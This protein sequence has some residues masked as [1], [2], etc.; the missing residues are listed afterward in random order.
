MRGWT[1]SSA[2]LILLASLATACA[3]PTSTPV[4]QG[5]Q[6]QPS[7]TPK[8]LT[9]VIHGNPAVFS[10]ILSPPGAAGSPPGLQ[11]MEELMNAGL[12]NADNQ[13]R[14]RPQL[15]EAV[16]SLENGLW[17]VQGD[18]RMETTWKIR[19]T[20]AWHDGTTFTSDDLVFAARV[21]R[22]VPE[23]ANTVWNLVDTVDSPDPGTVTI[24]WKRPFLN[25]DT[26]FS[27]LR[28]MPLPRH[29]LE[30]ALNEDKA[31]FADQPYWGQNFIGTGA[32]KLR[33]LVNGS[34]LIVDAN[35]QFVLGRL[36]IDTIEVKFAA[37][38]QTLM[39]TILANAADMSLGAR[40]SVDEALQVRDQWRDG[41]VE[42]AQTNWIVTYPQFL[43]PNPV[44]MLDLRFRRAL[45]H[46]I[47]RQQ[48]VEAIM[49]GITN[50]ADTT[51]G[52]NQVDYPEIES[53]V[54]RY[55]YDPSRTAQ[56][57]AELGYTKGADGSYAD[58]SGA[59]LQVEARATAQLDYQPKTLAAVADYWRRAGI[60]VDE[61]VVP[62]QQ[63]P[64]REYRHTR[65]GFEVLGLNNDPDNF[66]IFHSSR[67]PLPS[68]AFSGLN[69]SR[70]MNPE[71]DALVDRY[72]ETISRPERL[73]V[74]REIVHHLSDQLVFMGLFYTTT[75]S[76]IGNRVK[77]S[78]AR[79]PLST[80]AWNGE[81]W[82]LS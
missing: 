50:V 79:G 19:P 56:L 48:L 24:K 54:V 55:P 76:L 34:Y 47:D 28:G 62:N 40:I 21:G 4:S 44:V 36:K 53:S 38:A 3:P 2:T 63:V 66:Q 22:E 15:A 35:D 74:E 58:S 51:V 13:G 31:T 60:T 43:N 81:Q 16:P 12:S 67:T 61:I 68:N 69:R 49:Y 25:A 26:M 1:R 52:P 46:A 65:P 5:A 42:F 70:Y 30:K 33:E 41:H 75:H 71:Y 11:E 18:G 73:Q 37:D 10:T 78:T 23:F 82:E 6:P 27:R 64:D 14:L 9:A 77:N 59:K 57:L 80:D 20:A 32:F 7:A 72:L 8:R 29:L 17:T 39:T 45:Q